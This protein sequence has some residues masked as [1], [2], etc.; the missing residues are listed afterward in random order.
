MAVIVSFA[1]PKGIGSIHAPGIGAVRT[2]EVVATDAASTASAQEGEVAVVT[3]GET[4]PMLVAF[5]SAPDGDAA[6]SSATTSAGV[7]VAAGETLLL[8]VSKGDKVG[9]AALPS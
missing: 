5:G 2:M 6:A 3:N 1:T 9:V 8:A 7:G 4:D